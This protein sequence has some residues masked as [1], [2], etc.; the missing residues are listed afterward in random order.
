MLV[1]ATASVGGFVEA[2]AIVTG[3]GVTFIASSGAGC[4]GVGLNG[5]GSSPLNAEGAAGCCAS[6]V[7]ARNSSTDGVR[8]VAASCNVPFVIAVRL[9]TVTVPFCC[10]WGCTLSTGAAVGLTVARVATTSADAF[11]GLGVNTFALAVASLSRAG[12]VCA[13][14]ASIGLEFLSG[15]G[16]VLTRDGGANVWTVLRLAPDSP[17][18]ICWLAGSGFGPGCATG[19]EIKP[20]VIFVS[21]GLPFPPL[22]LCG[23]RGTVLPTMRLPRFF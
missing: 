19:A 15:C 17:D 14:V 11:F 22:D 18:L 23:P 9:L 8:A 5:S 6:F 12:L 3:D 20:G 2:V 16:C 7:S 10:C 1:S 13:A 21:E 4:T